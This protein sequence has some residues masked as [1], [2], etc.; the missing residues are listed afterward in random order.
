MWE[1]AKDQKSKMKQNNAANNA[2]DSNII[3][4]N[5][6]KSCNRLLLGNDI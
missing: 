4:K 1:V 6:C 3:K 5:V 2:Q